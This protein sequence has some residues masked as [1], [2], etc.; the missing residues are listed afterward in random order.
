M[1]AFYFYGGMVLTIFPRDPSISFE[2]HLFGAM[3]GALC[4]WLFRDWD[5]KP[6]LRRYSW[7]SESEGEEDP[8]IGDQWQSGEPP[9]VDRDHPESPTRT[10]S[11]ARIT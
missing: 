2:S 5:P 4:A 6:E 3:A 11:K 7:Q 9:S 8:V 1:V 10:L